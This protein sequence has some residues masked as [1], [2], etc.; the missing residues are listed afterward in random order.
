MDHGFYEKFHWWVI[1]EKYA[2]QY[3]PI[4]KDEDVIIITHYL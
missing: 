3:N 4:Y 1:S 2:L